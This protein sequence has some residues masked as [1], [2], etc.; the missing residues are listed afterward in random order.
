M[1]CTVIPPFPPHP[2]SLPSLCSPSP[3]LS[4]LG[5]CWKGRRHVLAL[6]STTPPLARCPATATSPVCTAALAWA[7]RKKAR[8]M[9]TN[10]SRAANPPKAPPSLTTPRRVTRTTLETWIPPTR[11]TKCLILS[12]L[13][14]LHYSLS[15]SQF[16]SLPQR[17]SQRGIQCISTYSPLINLPLSHRAAVL[18]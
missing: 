17:G 9:M 18:L 12:S 5:N 4:I 2:A 13:C 15:F 8:R 16:N 6:G 10:I 11:K 1:Y 3:L 7:G 14:L